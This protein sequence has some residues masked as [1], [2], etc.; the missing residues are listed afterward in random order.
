[1]SLSVSGYNNGLVYSGKQ[2]GD[3]VGSGVQNRFQQ[4][5]RWVREVA[6]KKKF[7]FDFF[8]P[9]RICSRGRS[10]RYAHYFNELS[11]AVQKRMYTVRCGYEDDCHINAIGLCTFF[12]DRR[13]RVPV[14]KE[15]FEYHMRQ[16]RHA[17]KKN[18]VVRRTAGFSSHPRKTM[19]KG[20]NKT[21]PEGKFGVSLLNPENDAAVRSPLD[22]NLDVVEELTVEPPTC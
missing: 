15:A 13:G 22:V 12:H 4:R 8:S 9:S 18:S 16:M 20:K 3:N 5:E 14:S 11:P 19:E 1:M 17:K 21:A 6:G 2:V 7:C 10:C